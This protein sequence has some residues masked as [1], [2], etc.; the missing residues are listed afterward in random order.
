MAE[1]FTRPYFEELVKTLNNDA[2]F[3]AK[4]GSLTATILMV[5][6]TK[7][8][9]YLLAIDKGTASVSDARPDTKAD[10]AFLGDHDTWVRNHNGEAPMEKLVMT[11]K[12]KFK[13]SIPRIMSLRSQLG[14]IDNIAQRVP[15]D[16]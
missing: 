10:F 14:V 5:D 13:G 12:L 16:A 2:E 7:D 3:K 9:A 6:T 4:T 11:G 8:A 1:L 15:A